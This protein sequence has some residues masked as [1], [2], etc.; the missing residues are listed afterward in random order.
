MG[1]TLAENDARRFLAAEAAGTDFLYIRDEGIEEMSFRTDTVLTGVRTESMDVLRGSN[2]FVT[3]SAEIDVEKPVG[4]DIYFSEQ[5][6]TID[7]TDEN[8]QEMMSSVL[9][10]IMYEGILSCVDMKYGE[11]YTGAALEGVIFISDLTV[12]FD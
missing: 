6:Q 10:K 4:E 9:Y 11:G 5:E 1:K 12:V 7:L 3:A 8:V 2:V